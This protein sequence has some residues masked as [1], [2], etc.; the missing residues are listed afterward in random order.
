MPRST[1]ASTSTST[2]TSAAGAG[3]GFV[4]VYDLVSAADSVNSTGPADPTE[5][6]VIDFETVPYVPMETTSPSPESMKS[7]VA[8]AVASALEATKRSASPPVILYEEI[9]VSAD[10]IKFEISEE[11]FYDG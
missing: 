3:T 2:G 4:S 6:S 5:L 1:S 8:S 9:E 11:A 10:D 7:A